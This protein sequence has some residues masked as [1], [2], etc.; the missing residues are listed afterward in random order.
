[1]VEHDR[2]DGGENQRLNIPTTGT[3][4]PKHR[5][6]YACLTR[7]FMV[8]C[9]KTQFN[10]VSKPAVGHASAYLQRGAPVCSATA[11]V[12]PLSAP[13]VL[14]VSGGVFAQGVAETAEK[15]IRRP[16]LDKLI[17]QTAA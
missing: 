11:A 4:C 8:F 2:V 15:Y 12:V 3:A 9:N 16:S 13:R 10:E 5:S 7:F 6:L 1:M 14:P 17:D